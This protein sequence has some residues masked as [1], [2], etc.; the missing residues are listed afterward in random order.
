M[1]EVKPIITKRL[2][3]TDTLLSLNVG[4]E[5][6]LSALYEMTVRQTISRLRTGKNMDFTA[7]RRDT[8]LF[9]IRIK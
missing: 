9:V 8:K 5:C 2:A 7:K 3:V 6:V 4:D 1:A